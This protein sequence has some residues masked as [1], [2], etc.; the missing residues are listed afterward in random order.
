MLSVYSIVLS[1]NSYTEKLTEKPSIS[2][3]VVSMI[4]KIRNFEAVT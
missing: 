1:T 3:L 2:V 4:C